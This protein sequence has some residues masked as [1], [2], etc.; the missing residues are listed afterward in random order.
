MR[1]SFIATVKQMDPIDAL[2]LNAANTK[3]TNPP[4]IAIHLKAI[5]SDEIIV[6][7]DHLANLN[8]VTRNFDNPRMMPFGKL[9]MN[10]VSD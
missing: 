3:E 5:S 2:V 10:A 1:Q 4:P 6:S 8:C 9:L 7:L